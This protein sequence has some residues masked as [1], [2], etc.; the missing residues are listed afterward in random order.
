MHPVITEQLAADHIRE[1]RARAE[2][3]CR[4]SQARRARRARRAQRRTPSIRPSGVVAG[5]FGFVHTFREQR[6]ALARRGDG[7]HKNG[8]ALEDARAGLAGKGEG[9]LVPRPHP[10]EH[11]TSAKTT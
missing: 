11:L 10:H 5:V 2:A 9:L 1:I 7:L 8:G 6:P 3:E 4:A